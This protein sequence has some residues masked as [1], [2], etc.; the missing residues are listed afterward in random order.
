M[1]RRSRTPTPPERSWAGGCAVQPSASESTSRSDVEH[2]GGAEPVEVGRVALDDLDVRRLGRTAPSG[3][4]AQREADLARQLDGLRVERRRAGRADQRER[5]RGIARRAHVARTRP[6]GGPAGQPVEHVALGR[7]DG[8]ATE[9]R[10]TSA[11]RSA[12][13]PGHVADRR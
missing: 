2:R 4:A 1:R 8:A 11:R 5:G 13:A 12:Q 10:A 7:V 9:R 6:T 3:D